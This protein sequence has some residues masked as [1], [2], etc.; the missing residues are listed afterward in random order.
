MPLSG[1]GDR[2]LLRP[3]KQTVDR[4]GNHKGISEDLNVDS[5]QPGFQYRQVS[6]AG[7]GKYVRRRERQ[8]YRVV[9]AD[10]PEMQLAKG[11]LNTGENLDSVHTS[12]D[13]ILMRIPVE[14]HQELRDEK[15]RLTELAMTGAETA[16]TDRG[17]AVKD[18]LGTA[19]PAEPLYYG[20]SRH[21]T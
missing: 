21:D 4:I 1:G 15:R 5:P 7:G 10:S 11:D 2:A 18:Q 12:K 16:F 3:L 20:D 19:A 14:K 17:E 13:V 9:T 6:T 8:G